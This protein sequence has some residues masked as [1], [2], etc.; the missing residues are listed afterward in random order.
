[1]WSCKCKVGALLFPI[2]LGTCIGMSEYL[3]GGRRMKKVVFAA[4]GGNGPLRPRVRN[5]GI[6]AV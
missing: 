6:Y 5:H 4:L 2:L 1:M 3:G